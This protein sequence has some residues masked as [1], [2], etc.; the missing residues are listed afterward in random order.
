MS[1]FELKAY[2]T[3][4]GK[5]NEGELVGEWVSFPV[6][7]EEM[8]QV[9]DRIGINER[10][11]EWFITD[12][13]TDLYG[14]SDILGEYTNLEK[15]N[16]LAG[17]LEELASYELDEYKAVLE[18]GLGLPEDDLDGL[19]NLT[20]NLDRYDI[21]PDVKDEDDLGRYWVEESGVYDTKNMGNLANYI[22]Y[23][24]F[25]RD[26]ALDEG[27]MFTDAGYIRDDCSSWDYEFDGELDSIPDE[28]RLSASGEMEETNEMTVL[29]VEPMKEP[30]V[31]TISSDLSSLQSEVA[32]DIEAVYPYAD[33]VCLIVN[34]EGKIN[35]LPLNRG[36]YD[37]EGNLYDITAGTFLVT[38]LTEDDFGSLTPEQIEKF[39]E[40][41]RTPEMFVQING[42]IKAIPV[43]A[44]GRE[45]TNQDMP[46]YAIYQ[47]D[48]QNPARRDL[49]FLSYDQLQASGQKLDSRN[50]TCVYSGKLNPGE[51]LDSIYERFNLHHPADFRG[52]SLSVSDVVVIH[53]NGQDQAH[54]VD[55]FGFKQVPE[56]FAHNPLEKVE[57]LL[58]DDYGMIDGIINNGDRRKE[59][60]PEKKPSVMEKLQEKKA[61][62]AQIEQASPKPKKEKTQEA[63][64]S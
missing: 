41:F 19:I 22:D 35:G 9:F 49:S 26:I 24:R 51:T 40:L 1:D 3:N 44:N 52:H 56:F 36:L 10:Y 15:L 27:G 46:Q 59:Q 28:Y 55:S 18:S 63:D 42:E 23:E 17:R 4:L 29:V 58:E 62:A 31:K 39:T 14:I 34:E 32:G 11:E 60:E 53:Q 2:V 7:A 6:T 21:I 50:Y 16:Y 64:L 37:D 45:E 57:E 13:D 12:Y 25:G 8:Q 54:Y 30:Y 38:G 20:Y 33:P 5:Y 43:A 61:E 48:E 47:L